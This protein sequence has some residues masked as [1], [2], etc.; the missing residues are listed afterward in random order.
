MAQKKI[1]T[2]PELVE[3]IEEL[4]QTNQPQQALN[5]L[6]NRALNATFLVPAKLEQEEGMVEGADGKV[7]FENRTTKAHFML[8]K[9]NTGGSFFPAFTDMNEYKKLKNAEEGGF[10]PVALTFFDLAGMSEK[11]GG[12]DR[13]EKVEGFVINPI[14]HNYP[15]TNERLAQIRELLMKVQRA[16]QEG[17]VINPDGSVD[18]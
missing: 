17:K 7:G 8:L 4:R 11:A 12:E 16:Q 3:A 10:T 2:N 1:I 14:T 9:H 18:E 6:I 15:F 5:N 13:P